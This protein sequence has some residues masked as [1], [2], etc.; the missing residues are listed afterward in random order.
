VGIEGA[1]RL[2]AQAANTPAARQRGL[3]HCIQHSAQRIRVVRA[4]HPQRRAK[5]HMQAL[6]VAMQGLAHIDLGKKRK[7]LF[8]GGASIAAQPCP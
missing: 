6:C 4:Q 1:G 8:H 3:L 7:A 5:G 2:I